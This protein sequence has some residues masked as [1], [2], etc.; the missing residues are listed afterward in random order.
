ME[1]VTDTVF[2]QIVA[3][4][5]RPDVFF[6]EFTNCEGAQ[7]A[8]QAA[9]VKRL[10]YTE[11]ERPLV[12]QIWGI[13]PSDY[14]KTAQMIAELGFDGIDINMG[15][16]VKKIIKQGACSALIK[17]P[18]LA[19]EIILATRE[20]AGNLPV[21]VKTRI[22]FNQIQTEEWIGFLLKEIQPEV[23]TI[24]GRTV[25]EASKVPN[26]WDEIGKVAQLRNQL[27]PETLVVGN[28]DIISMQE[29]VD[30]CNEFNLDGY[31]IGRGI[32]QNLWVFNPRIDPAEVPIAKRLQVLE[33]H[34][35]LFHITWG[36]TKHFNLMKKYFKIY[37]NTFP[38]AAEMRAELMNCNSAEEVLNQLD[39]YKND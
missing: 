22:G 20:G 12:A 6:T 29:G 18:S 5:G 1:D 35:K 36:T 10:K 33:D 39:K 11:N 16:P 31:M 27:S 30:K 28:G 26:H 34:V 24:H 4:E 25:K 2:R 15:C 21:S 14:F 8:G 17:N 9:V 13:T 38:G 19:K 23:L 37:L 7:S 3:Q 32:F